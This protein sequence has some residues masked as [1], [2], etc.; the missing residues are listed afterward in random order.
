[1]GSPENSLLA[2][3]ASCP[4]C[5]SSRRREGPRG[6]VHTVPSPAVPQQVLTGIL[7]PGQ[8]TFLSQ[9]TVEA[10]GAGSTFRAQG[11]HDRDLLP[12]GRAGPGTSWRFWLPQADSGPWSR[13]LGVFFL[14]FKCLRIDFRE[15]HPLVVRLLMHPRLPLVCALS[16]GP[17]PGLPAWACA[18]VRACACVCVRVLS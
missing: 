17:T 13:E 3:P 10:R 11:A 14:I 18:C 8:E 4:G 15:K 9:Q 7:P 2:P 6:P 12:R 16:G 5:S 1:M